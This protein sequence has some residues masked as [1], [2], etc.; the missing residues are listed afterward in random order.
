MQA[1]ARPIDYLGVGSGAERTI[2]AGAG[3][4]P[5]PQRTRRRRPADVEALNQVAAV[6]AQQLQRL[7]VLDPLGHD[8]QP[9]VVTKVD[10]RLHDGRAVPVG[11]HVRHERLVDLDLTDRQALQVGQ[12]RVARAEVIDGDLD[13]D[14]MQSLQGFLRLDGDDGALG[15]L[16]AEQLLRTWATASGSSSSSRLRADR[17]TETP[18]SIPAF[19]QACTWPRAS[20]STQ[21]VSGLI[22]SVCSADGMKS[23]GGSSPWLGWPQRTS[24][25]TLDGWPSAVDTIGW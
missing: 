11:R 7:F 1:R 21:A 20:L 6:V 13:A 14:S 2:E 17:L 8:A 9:Q 24:A 19:D 15:D 12:G 16:Q 22:R 25:S 10:G 5:G 18:M 4:Q 3:A 23:S